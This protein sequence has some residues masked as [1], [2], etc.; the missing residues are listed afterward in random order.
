MDTGSFFENAFASLHK[1]KPTLI[2]VLEYESK[3][4]ACGISENDA[5]T[6][7]LLIFDF[8][9]KLYSEYPKKISGAS[10]K[11]LQDFRRTAEL[12][13]EAI[14]ESTKADLAQAV[15]ACS[16]QVASSVAR[17]AEARWVA[18]CLLAMAVIVVGVFGVGYW[19]GAEAGRIAGYNQTID[20]KMAAEW[21]NTVPGRMGYELWQSG[22]L[23]HLR[24]C[25]NPGWVSEKRDSG[26]FCFPHAQ[27]GI[28]YGWRID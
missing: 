15:V 17:K 24:G 5:F 6:W 7:V 14:K 28:V 8:Y 27:D 18:G 13:I 21:A 16:R 9:D 11:V 10:K 20:V 2:E 12:E 3:L 4:K 22:A 19:K 23:E 26:T 25:T 1:R